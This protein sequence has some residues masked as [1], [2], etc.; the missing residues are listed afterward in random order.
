MSVSI[1]QALDIIYENTPVLNFEILPIE[2]SL[3]RILREDCI[4]S[5]DLPRFDNSAMDGYAIKCID[6]GTTVT[7][8]EIIYAGDDPK[9]ILE[10]QSAIKIMTGAPLPRGCEAVVPVENVTQN[11]TQ[12][13]LPHNIK[14]YANLRRA[15]EDIKSG[16]VYLH[17]GD[18]ITA[19]SIALLASQGITHIRVTRPVKVAVFGTGN[20]L[21]PHFDKIEAHQLY[22]SN[23]PMFLARAKELGCEVEYIGS[24][25]D[26]I[27]SLESSIESALNADIILT[28]GGVSMGD[29][30]FTKDAF[31]N[32]G[33]RFYFEKVDIKPGKPT[34]FGILKNTVIVNLPGNPLASMVNYEIFVRTVIRKMSGVNACYHGIVK[35][36]MEHDF[37]VKGGKNTVL[38]GTFNGQSFTPLKVQMPGMV[39][40]L[41]T[42]DGFIL[43]HPDIATL[44]KSQA[45]NMIPIK[46]DFCSKQKADLFTY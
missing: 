44:H 39:S 26:T 19:Y 35:T 9:L 8:S 18:K 38:L 40:P 41:K 1:P 29:K 27:D 10:E 15:G 21:H 42:A 46:W 4:A 13:T 32:M 3:G 25:D 37:E 45:V 12:I 11:D 5:F 14:M 16:T 17:K 2:N 36:V 30:D 34:A 7:C 31:R 20:E 23:T 28:S 33:A 43:L 22:N 24:C 6:A